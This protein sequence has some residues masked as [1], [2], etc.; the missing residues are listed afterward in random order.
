MC[1]ALVCAAGALWVR[2]GGAAGVSWGVSGLLLGALVVGFC[3]FLGAL[4]KGLVRVFRL[5]SSQGG[6][7]AL[8]GLLVACGGPLGV[9]AAFRA[10]GAR[11][12]LAAAEAYAALV[13]ILSLGARVAARKARA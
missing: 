13:L 10:A 1:L 5:A 9:L 2:G 7:A 6:G 4:C 12:G 3:A 8:A 11:G